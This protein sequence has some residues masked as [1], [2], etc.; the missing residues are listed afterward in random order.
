MQ[1]TLNIDDTKADM[2]LELLKSLDFVQKISIKTP[3]SKLEQKLTPPQ[4]DVWEG[5]KSGLE[6]LKQG[7]IRPAS[8]FLNE[9][10]IYK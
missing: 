8:D 5:I 2:F 9:L 6:D 4:Q 7:K 1:I 10:K 3:L